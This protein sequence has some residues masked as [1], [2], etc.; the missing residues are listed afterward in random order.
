MCGVFQSNKKSTGK[1]VLSPEW[2]TSIDSEFAH[3]F[4]NGERRE[5]E[6]YV[7]DSVIGLEQENLVNIIMFDMFFP[8]EG[9]PDAEI[10]V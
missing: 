3:L 9:N 7:R 6:D 2:L 5:N 8:V 4:G 10:A 1:G